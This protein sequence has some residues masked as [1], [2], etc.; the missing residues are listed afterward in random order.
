MKAH[1]FYAST[2]LALA[3][4]SGPALQTAQASGLPAGTL[5]SGLSS[6]QA[7]ALLGLD[8]L[9]ADIPGSNITHLAA[10]DLEYLTSDY[11]VGIDFLSNGELNLYNNGGSAELAGSYKLNFSF[12]GLTQDISGLSISDQ[13]NLLSGDIAPAWVSKNQIAISFSNLVFKDSYQSITLQISTAAAVPEP[14]SWALLTAGLGLMLLA[15]RKSG[16]RA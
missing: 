13:S 7:Q 2:L 10:D 1:Q 9:F 12:A 15:R 16:V 11:Q 6:G 5:I 4:L 3:S 14:A 8:S